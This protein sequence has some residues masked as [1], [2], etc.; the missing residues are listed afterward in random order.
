[1]FLSVLLK[2]YIIIA[3]TII[4]VPMVILIIVVD[5]IILMQDIVLRLFSYIF[6]SII[7]ITVNNF[8][9]YFIGN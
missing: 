7:D 8:C 3:I 5:F 6:F 2:G 4:I 9:V 1:M